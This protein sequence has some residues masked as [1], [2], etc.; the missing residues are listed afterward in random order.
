MNPRTIFLNGDFFSSGLWRHC[1]K[2]LWLVL[3]KLTGGL[4]L[5]WTNLHGLYGYMVTA[6]NFRLSR[7]T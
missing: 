3:S 6:L 2:D 7:R 5:S 1:A 4:L